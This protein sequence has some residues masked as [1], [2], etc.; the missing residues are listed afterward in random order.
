MEKVRIDLNENS[1]DIL[2]GTNISND[3]NVLIDKGSEHNFIIT[4]KNV[5]RLYGS[6]LDTFGGYDKIVIEPGEDSKSIHVVT[7]IL[8][9]MLNKGASRKSKVIAFGGGVVGDLAGFCSAIYMRG[10]SFIQVPTTL[11]SQIDSSVGGKTGINLLHCKNSVGAFHQP[12]KVIIDI[13]FLH[14]L[15]SRELLSGIGEIIK[16]GIIYDYKF[17]KYIIENI[18]EIKKCND[19]IMLYVV[20]RCCEIKAEIVSQDEKEKGLRKILNFGHTIGHAL[21]GI[22]GFS[23]YTHGEAVI[24]GM[25]HETIM[26]RRLGL[27]D[28]KY[29]EEILSFLEDLNINLDIGGYPDS[30]LH[31]WMLKDKKNI[32]GKVSFILPVREGQVSEVLL[33]E[34]EIFLK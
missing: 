28:E 8:E 17:L 13:R 14:T 25:C 2:I 6:S 4:D 29:A 20:K 32:E 11:L 12:D 16:Y 18:D 10:I 33:D 9:Q 15:P 3:L 34:D 1:Y 22:T 30:E 23:K 19:E 21:E 26:A 27:I 24:I 7:D 31:R 5:D